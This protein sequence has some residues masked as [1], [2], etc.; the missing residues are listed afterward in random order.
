MLTKKYI[1]VID[2][3]VMIILGIFVFIFLVKCKSPDHWDLKYGNPRDPTVKDETKED[4]NE[5]N[6]G[7]IK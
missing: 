7:E 4:N 5:K 6:K 3:W 1:E 2:T